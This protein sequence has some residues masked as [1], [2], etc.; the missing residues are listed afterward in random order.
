MKQRKSFMFLTNDFK[1]I[2][3][4]RIDIGLYTFA[5]RLCRKAIECTGRKD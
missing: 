3:I 4:S 2:Y 1:V 5:Y